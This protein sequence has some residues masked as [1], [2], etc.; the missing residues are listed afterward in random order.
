M[1]LIFLKNIIKENKI[2]LKFVN[3]NFA[4]FQT[5]LILAVQIFSGVYIMRAGRGAS[6]GGERAENPNKPYENP[7]V[8][9]GC[10]VS[11]TV[12]LSLLS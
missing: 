4:Q 8:G 6:Q 11:A 5:R 1:K 9:V 10:L 2:W 7:A 3:S 12:S